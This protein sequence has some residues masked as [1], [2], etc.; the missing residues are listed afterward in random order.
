[1]HNP[2]PSLL[3]IYGSQTGNAQDAAERVAREANRRH[4]HP[5]LLS[6][7]TYISS[8][9]MLSH[10]PQEAAVIFIISTTGQ[11]EP[12]SNFKQLWKFLLK[13]SLPPDSLSASNVAVFGL[14]DSGY[15]QY[16]VMA[17]KVFRRLQ[18]LGAN[19]V[20]PLGLGDDQHRSG[21]EAGLD[22]WLPVLWE[23][24]SKQFPL[25]AVPSTS[26]GGDDG[27]GTVLLEPPHDDMSTEIVSKYTIEW[28]DSSTIA[29]LG[30]KN[31]N[32]NNNNENHQR[33]V[34]AAVVFA[35]VEAAAS[36][37]PMII[38]T[39]TDY[40]E[41]SKATL[42]D[43]Y[44]PMNP[45]FA[46]LTFNKRITAEDHFQDVRQLEFDL[47]GYPSQH[48]EGGMMYQP[49]D[50]LA[51]LPKQSPQAVDAFLATCNL[52]PNAWVR[53]TPTN[54]TAN[55]D[56]DGMLSGNGGASSSSSLSSSSSVVVQVGPL[57]AGALDISGASPRRYFFQVMA[58][59]SPSELERGR[60]SYFAS[61]QGSSDLYDYNQREGRTVLEILADF[62]STSSALG[63]E[64]L[65][66]CC[67]RLKPRYF[68][69]AS[70]Q[71]AHPNVAQLDVAIV[72]WTT[73]LKR[74]RKGM[75][76]KWLASLE[77]GDRV[78]VWLEKG[79][80]RL[81][82]SLAKMSIL[83]GGGEQQTTIATLPPMIM[84]GP[85][86][87]VA[88]FRSFLQDIDSQ[89]QTVSPSY[90]PA[91][92]PCLLF[93]GCRN[94]TKDYYH[95]EEWEAMSQ[96]V[97]V[98]S[99]S[100]GGVVAA[101]SRDQE[102]KDYVQHKIKGCAAGRVWEMLER[103]AWVYV[104]GSAEKMPQDVFSALV[105]VLEKEGCM[106]GEDARKYLKQKEMKGQ[107]QVECWN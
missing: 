104:A 58:Q 38:P 65:L 46:T 4:F 74:I 41:P 62:K 25:I 29:S 34:E 16:N 60:L 107:Y 64:W 10:F 12:P 94:K 19:M 31:N 77:S 51:I 68:S 49:G 103:G 36:G 85:G 50:V 42:K 69:I 33:A 87:G 61:P 8:P 73:P 21:Y 43:D 37:A 18:G 57:V 56:G 97:R 96:P 44:G 47:S 79:A 55:E 76:S 86:T 13:K 72:R 53:I 9:T 1:M 35:K 98:L 80:L 82:P 99:T 89:L 28:L 78:P 93:F 102:G 91:P 32:N 100:P 30:I 2:R 7:D 81:P 90:I 48:E 40:S 70:S 67:P 63:L 105:E 6:A 59:L 66:T 83:K 11:G 22:A 92:P 24:L 71:R 54:G 84:I 75:C 39:N 101:F 95:E 45:F 3:I 27:G 23:A 5:R 14:G 52:D 20:A 26:G 15:I 17:K 88:P 106:S